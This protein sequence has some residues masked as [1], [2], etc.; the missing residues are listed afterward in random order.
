MQVGYQCN[1]SK[2]SYYG[3]SIEAI[4]NLTRYSNKDIDNNDSMIIDVQSIGSSFLF[5]FQVPNSVARHH[6]HTHHVNERRSHIN[7]TI[8]KNTLI[9]RLKSF[10][11]EV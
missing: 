1:S 2:S 6:V 4:E 11:N 3:I 10:I 9:F 5:K 8:L 7:Y